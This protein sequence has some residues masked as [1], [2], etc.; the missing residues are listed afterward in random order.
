MALRAPA[1]LLLSLGVLLVVVPPAEAKP[2]RGKTARVAETASQT[3]EQAGKRKAAPKPAPRPAPPKPAFSVGPPNDGKLLGGQRLDTSSPHLRVVPAYLPGDVRWGLPSL[4]SM[5]ERAARG[6]AKR[7]PGAVLEVGDLSRRGGGEVVRHHSHESGRDVDLGFYLV[8]AKGRA[9]RPAT[10]VAVDASLR[11][12]GLPG[13]RFDVA[14]NWALVELMLGDPQAKVT[15]IFVAEHLR[16]ALLAHAR[17]RGVS[18]A[19]RNRAAWTLLQPT[20]VESHD[21]HMHVRIACPRS[22]AGRCVEI[23][24]DAPMGAKARKPVPRAKR[25]PVAPV[26]A[27]P[28]VPL[29]APAPV[30]VPAPVGDSPYD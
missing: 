15:H 17:Q 24:K 25:R 19:L 21:D 29:A 22:S 16:Q 5:I 6:V 7:Y 26:L 12:P 3:D 20:S 1:W 30:H 14:R 2:R 23:S 28:R 18:P 4:V 9:L 10:F 13:A 8:D 27:P 11:A